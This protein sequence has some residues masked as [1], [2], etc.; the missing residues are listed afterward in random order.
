MENTDDAGLGMKKENI[1]LIT[2]AIVDVAATYGSALLPDVM[3]SFPQYVRPVFLLCLF[4]ALI[5]SFILIVTVFMPSEVSELLNSIGH[6]GK[7][8]SAKVKGNRSHAEGATGGRGGLGKGGSGGNASVEGNKSYARGGVGGDAQ[9]VAI[10]RHKKPM[11]IL[12][13]CLVLSFALAYGGLKMKENSGGRGGNARVVGD[14]SGGEGGVGGQGGKG[15]GGAGG[16]VEVLGNN[17]FA[18]GGDGG[19]AAQSDGR[20][21]RRTLSQSE[22]M[23]LPTDTWHFGYGGAG[24]N[25][26]EYDRRLSLLIEIREGYLQAFPNDAV[27][28]H[29]GVDQV[30]LRWINKRLEELQENWRVTGINDE[31]GYIMPLLPDNAEDGAY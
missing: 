7:G 13:F 8:G 23:N 26:E 17:S 1:L 4:L 22:R 21:G 12:F 19:N 16:D 2:T 29:S 5:S 11:G 9:Q 14:N 28:I 20:G 30:P 25:A 15:P 31:G 27:F 10:Q 3:Q 18:R 24:A 6:G